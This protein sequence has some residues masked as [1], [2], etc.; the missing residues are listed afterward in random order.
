M[1]ITKMEE[2]SLIQKGEIVTVQLDEFSTF[3]N[4]YIVAGM[5]DD[6]VLLC[7]PIM[8]DLFILRE[9]AELN[10][11]QPRLKNELEKHLEFVMKHRNLLDYVG[12]SEIE[13]IVAHFIRTKQLTKK[14]RN[15]ISSLG[16][17]ISKIYF[18]T[19]LSFARKII[20][21]NVPLLDEYNKAW[22]MNSVFNKVLRGNRPANPNQT[23]IIFNMAG[24]VLSQLEVNI[25]KRKG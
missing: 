17:E 3:S 11:V 21:E 20:T 18:N 13:S 10:T 12:Q 19:E 4:T 1:G 23:D 25:V 24:F 5:A 22:F 15:N 6:K 16:G 9:E 14:H 2:T 7:H 8:P